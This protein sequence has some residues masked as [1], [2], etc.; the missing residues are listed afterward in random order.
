MP[1]VVLLLPTA[2]YRAPDFLAAANRQGVEVVVA[3]EE[4]STMEALSPASLIT[5][6]F[7]DPQACAERVAQFHEA[8][9]VDALIPVDEKTAVVAAAIGERLGLPHNPSLSARRA[10]SKIEMRRALSSAG[11]AGPR[12][13]RLP[14]ESIARGMIDGDWS[15]A[16]PLVVKPIAMSGSRGVVRASRR[17]EFLSVVERVSSIARDADAGESRDLLIE[18]FMPGFEVAVEAIADY[19]EDGDDD[20]QIAEMI[21]L[22]IFDKPDPLDGP[23]FEETLYVTPSRLAPEIQRRVVDTTRRAAKAIGLRHGP[24][25]AELRVHGGDVSVVEIAGRSIGGL[26]SRCLKFGLGQSLEELILRH[27]LGQPIET[28]RESA[29][30]GVMMLPIPSVGVLLG[31]DGQDDAVSVPGIVGLNITVSR[32]TRLVPLPEASVYLGFLFARGERAADVESS[33]RRAYEKLD[34]RISSEA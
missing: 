21:P 16:F 34:F 10:R 31:V 29:S 5:L 26:C 6:D 7:S 28:N 4:P 20:G 1:R 17:E 2:S 23:F 32:G 13:W 25:H 19:D 11:I 14:A 33:L 12:Y 30:S 22:A 3:S 9:P 15:S 18:T 24:I 27:A 8:L